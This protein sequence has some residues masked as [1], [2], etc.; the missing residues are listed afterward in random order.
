MKTRF[1]NSLF[2]TKNKDNDIRILGKDDIITIL[3]NDNTK[4][5]RKLRIFKWQ[6]LKGPFFM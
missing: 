6:G 5:K 4:N 1:S 2:K 3:E